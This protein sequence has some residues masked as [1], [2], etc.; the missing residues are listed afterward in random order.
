MTQT[1]TRYQP[2]YGVANLTIEKIRYSLDEIVVN[3][4]TDSMKN[5]VITRRSGGK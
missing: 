4:V 3:H 2:F 5:D 1:Y